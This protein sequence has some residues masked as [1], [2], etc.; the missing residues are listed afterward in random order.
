MKKII[1]DFIDMLGT[2]DSGWREAN[3]NIAAEMT[4]EFTHED[5]MWLLD[6]AIKMPLYLQERCAE[7]IGYLEREEAVP[8]LI[9]LL[10]SDSLFILSIAASEL[11]NM[12]ISLPS[13][14]KSKL[15]D[16]IVYLIQKNSTRITEVQALLD[17][18]EK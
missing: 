14:F 9:S 18:L 13:S 12:S 17:K 15:E 4:L 11:G 6:N 7:A 1:Q 16:L 3:L 8:T 2:E 10:E 5:W